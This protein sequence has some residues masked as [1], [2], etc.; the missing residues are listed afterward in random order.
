MYF[1]VLFMTCCLK[2][3]TTLECGQAGNIFLKRRNICV[4]TNISTKYEKWSTSNCQTQ[5][6]LALH[7]TLQEAISEN[8]CL[9][10]PE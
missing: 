10:S 8:S 7:R 3:M 6:G 9:L 4:N 5:T 1:M 2:K